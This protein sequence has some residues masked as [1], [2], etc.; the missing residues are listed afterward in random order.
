MIRFVPDGDENNLATRQ[1]SEITVHRDFRDVKVYELQGG[2]QVVIAGDAWSGDYG[3]RRTVFAGTDESP[4]ATGITQEHLR[5]LQD[6]G[7]EAFYRGLMPSVIRRLEALL[8]PKV[9]DRQGDIA[10]AT[11]AKDVV[12]VEQLRPGLL[13]LVPITWR[14]VE[15]EP[16]LD[17]RH[18]LTG[19]IANAG[20]RIK[21]KGQTIVTRGCR[22]AFGRLDAEDHRS[23]DLAP[24]VIAR[25]PG[26]LPWSTVTDAHGVVVG[27]L[28]D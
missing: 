12:A 7:E 16:I 14:R 9:V 21:V 27:H 11:V 8:G 4:F 3:E 10:W 6:G 17:T 5:R 25:T 26:L 18:R 28:G 1:G 2:E 19:H 13:G 22:L 24:S 20:V 23:R 15:N